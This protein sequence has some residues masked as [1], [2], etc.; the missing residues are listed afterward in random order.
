[1]EDIVLKKNNVV[2]RVDSED[3]ARA[4]EAKGFFRMDGK[5][6]PAMVAKDNTGE[7]LKELTDTKVKLQEVTKKAELSEKE[8]ADIKEQL[9]VVGKKNKALEEE[10]A[11][12][13]EQLEVAIKKNKAAEKK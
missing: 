5:M 6:A 3:K 12:T 7:L 13:K 4:L 2:K 11:G 8:L 1:M 10:L 9:E